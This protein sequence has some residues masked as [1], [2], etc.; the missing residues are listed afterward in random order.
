MGYRIEYTSSGSQRKP[1]KHKP[2]YA[3]IAT[4]VGVLSLV[5]LAIAI[6]H[7]GLTWVRDVLLPGD[8]AIT[9]AALENMVDNMKSGISIGDAV[10]AFCQE[11]LANAQ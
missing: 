2:P 1:L 5:F 3:A 10:T 9:A 8:P 11:I 4:A 6:K 7:T